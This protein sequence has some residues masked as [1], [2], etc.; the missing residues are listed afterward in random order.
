M[1]R[2]HEDDAERAV[3]AAFGARPAAPGEAF[4]IAVTTQAARTL[5]I[6]TVSATKTTEAA[7]K[8]AA[9]IDWN[10]QYRSAD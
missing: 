7:R 10:S 2:L 6:Q 9:S 5:M 4:A 8:S 3:R 1:P